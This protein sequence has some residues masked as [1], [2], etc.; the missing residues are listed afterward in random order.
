MSVSPSSKYEAEGPG[1]DEGATADFGTIVDVGNKKVRNRPR[2]VLHSG[3][4]HRQSFAR[5][6]PVLPDANGNPPSLFLFF[7]FAS[8]AQKEKAGNKCTI[9]PRTPAM[10]SWDLFT[11]GLLFFTAVV[12]PVSAPTSLPSCACA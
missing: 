6:P 9:D 3:T 11:M 1:E 4:A 8:C 7:L 12:T 2:D 10:Q 5:A